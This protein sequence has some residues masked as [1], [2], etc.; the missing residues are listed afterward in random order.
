MIV[1]EIFYGVKCDRC[2]TICESGDDYQYWPDEDSAIECA[3]N[4]DWIEEKGKH[5]CP[6]CYAIDPETDEIK[7]L[8]S[9]PDHIKKIRDFLRYVAG[10]SANIHDVDGFT[11]TGSDYRY[12]FDQNTEAYIKSI[13]PDA[14]I[15]VSQKQY[16]YR[17]ITITI[18]AE[19]K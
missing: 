7:I 14:E 11:I 15:T 8:P 3:E 1:T 16:N 19:S 17:V 4:D 10:I 9:Y 2:G 18:N 5:Y 12:S 13:C 6:N